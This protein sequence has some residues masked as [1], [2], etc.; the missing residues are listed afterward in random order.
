MSIENICFVTDGY[1][2]EYRVVNA[3]VEN[4]VNAMVDVEVR[5]IVIAPQSINK[6]F[7]IKTKI[8]PLKRIRKT[9]AGNEVEV[10][11]PKY[12]SMS[13]RKIGVFNTAKITLSSFQR[14]AIKTFDKLHKQVRF[15][16]VYGHFIFEAGITANLIGEKYGI[17]AFLAYGENGTYSINYLGD[18]TTRKLLTG[19]TGIISVS[20]ENKRVLI[21]K[22]IASG[23]KIEVFP[24]AINNKLFF[25]KDRLQARRILA[26]PEDAFI[27]AFVGRFIEVKGPKR[28]SQAIEKLNDSQIFSIYLGEGSQ[29]PE[30]R[31]ILYMGPVQH[32]Q[33]NDYFNASDVFVLP[34]LAE[35]CCNAIIEAMACGLPIISSNLPFNDDILNDN[36]SIRLDSSNVDEIVEAIKKL[37]DNHELRNRLSEGAIKTAKQLTIDERAKNIL[38]FMNDCLGRD[39]KNYEIDN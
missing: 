39:K 25:P 19:I 21:K 18:E 11:T 6:A 17:P 28:L 4:L 26:F 29:K 20:S 24:N 12:L 15:D 7:K 31:N 22:N 16:A 3:F 36:N 37:K 33:L 8:L 9:P 2:S 23:E 27:I 1:P 35:G 38:S 14:A 34:T 30:C 32:N 5:C 10:Y 13:T